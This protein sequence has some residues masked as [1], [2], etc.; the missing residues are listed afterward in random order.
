MNKSKYTQY[1]ECLQMIADN[2]DIREDLSFVED[3]PDYICQYCGNLV[4]EVGHEW[5]CPYVVLPT[6][7]EHERKRRIKKSPEEIVEIA[8]KYK[9]GASLNA[10][11]EQYNV[12]ASTIRKWILKSGTKTRG[13]GKHRRPDRVIEIDEM[14]RLRFE[15]EYTIEEIGMLYG[16]TR[17]RIRQLIGNTGWFRRE[18]RKTPYRNVKKQALLWLENRKK[19]DPFDECWIWPFGVHPKFGFGR[20]ND[21]DDNNYT[22]YAHR[23]AYEYFFGEIPKY[24]WVQHTCNN[25]LCCNPDHLFLNKH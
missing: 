18:K 21:S 25:K 1:K 7:G 12:A 2:G 20:Y 16:I 14:R 13:R 19:N 5:S 9:Q 15:E 22:K 17:E 6:M 23:L 3:D 8:Q 11:G 24:A 4:W 10:L